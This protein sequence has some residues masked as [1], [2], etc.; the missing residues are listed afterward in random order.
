MTAATITARIVWGIFYVLTL[1]I[2]T[3]NSSDAEMRFVGWPMLLTRW[4]ARRNR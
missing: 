3:I 1:G 2:F 4:R